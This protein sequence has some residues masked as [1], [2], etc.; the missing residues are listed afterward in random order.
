[1]LSRLID[2]RRSL[3]VYLGDT[4]RCYACGF[5]HVNITAMTHHILGA[6]EAEPFNEED[7]MEMMPGTRAPV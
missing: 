4:W 2:H 7:I 3:P 5:E 6:H 1:M